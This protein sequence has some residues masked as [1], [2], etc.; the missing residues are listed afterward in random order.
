MR[1]GWTTLFLLACGL[2]GGCPVMQDQNTPVKA[3]HHTCKATGRGYYRY[4]PSTY[5]PKLAYP[6]V[7]T[8][9]GT[10]PW[11]TSVMQSKEWKALA[12]AKEFIVVAP[13][14]NS[15]EG[16]LPVAWSLRERTLKSDDEH[17]LAIL[18]ELATTHTINP[19][20]VLLSG[21]SAGG[22]AM[23]YTGLRHPARFSMLVARACNTD[24]KI[25]TT[26]TPTAATKKLPVVIMV[27]KYDSVLQ[28]HS[29]IAFRWLR[30][31]GWTREL[32]IRKEYEGGHLRRPADAYDWWN[33][34]QPADPAAKENK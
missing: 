5:D 2:L 1:H 23:Y 25:F 17:I 16:I 12:E 7:V 14:L 27:G 28:E 3:T 13:A 19:K 22:F 8:L 10:F 32:A 33:P 29:W 11:D 30:T 4:V 24:E 31:H 15:A 6:V 34:G 26:L 20:R 9:H 21:F 18:D